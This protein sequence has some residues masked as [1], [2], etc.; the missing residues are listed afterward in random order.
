MNKTSGADVL[1]RARP[2]G[3]ALLR[4]NRLPPKTRLDQVPYPRLICL[5]AA[6]MLTLP[7][8]PFDITW[9]KGAC[10]RCKMAKFLDAVQ[11]TTPQDA[12]AR[13]CRQAWLRPGAVT[14]QRPFCT[15]V[16]TTDGGLTWKEMP[17]IRQYPGPIAGFWM[18]A[19]CFLNPK[20]GWV[21]ADSAVDSGLFH[22]TDAGGHW[23]L[24]S[25]E[26]YENLTFLN[27]TLAFST[28][29]GQNRADML[30]RT[31]DGGRHWTQIEIPPSGLIERI[32]F[33]N[34]KTAWLAGDRILQ[35][36]DGGEHWTPAGTV[37]KHDAIL[38]LTF[39]DASRGWLIVEL[40]AASRQLYRT[41][42]AGK[43]WTPEPAL[44][45]VSG[46]NPACVRASRDGTIFAFFERGATQLF[47]RDAG[48]HWQTFS[49]PTP[50]G[51][52]LP[53]DI[54][55]CTPLENDLLCTAANEY[56]LRPPYTDEPPGFYVLK[57]GRT[58]RSAR[59]LP[60]ALFGQSELR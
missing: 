8:Q 47:S 49:L 42:D 11:F 50:T 2:P 4:R 13:A 57:V 12:W 14:G 60:A 55:A 10:P 46:R 54:R 32:F 52:K 9:T 39:I 41:T 38:D 40:N 17:Q 18:P 34:P 5:L 59:G 23:E 20:E 43:T 21:S 31:T 33:L 35:T 22:T 29:R 45:D 26:G 56:F 19:I 1:V 25:A 7:A 6:A 24:T 44:P 53:P 27:P 51:A 36:V 3:R 37:P 58:S 16:H 48:A 30:R 15:V 28:S